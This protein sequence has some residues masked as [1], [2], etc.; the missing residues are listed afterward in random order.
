M[1]VAGVEAWF[2]TH[3]AYLKADEEG[4][5]AMEGRTARVLRENFP[6]AETVEIPVM[7]LCWRTERLPR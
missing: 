3:S 7:T 4:K 2:R 5:R 1:P 6:G